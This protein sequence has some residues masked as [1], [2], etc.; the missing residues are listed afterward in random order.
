M[1]CSSWVASVIQVTNSNAQLVW[2]ILIYR[3]AASSAFLLSIQKCLELYCLFHCQALCCCVF[4]TNSQTFEGF[5]CPIPLSFHQISLRKK[6]YSIT[7]LGSTVSIQDPTSI[8]YL[9]CTWAQPTTCLILSLHRTSGFGFANR[10][11]KSEHI[12]IP[13]HWNH[14]R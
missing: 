2:G 8:L 4:S 13:Q 12:W 6:H 1:I 14:V 7:V 9:G 11:Q 3:Q 5:R 10:S